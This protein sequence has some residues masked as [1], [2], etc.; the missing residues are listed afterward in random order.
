MRSRPLSS[1]TDSRDRGQVLVIFAL[2]LLT[3]ILFAA[4]AFD[5]GQMLLERRDQQDA[6]DAA[7]LAG[8]Y[9]LPDDP[10]T[11]RA[12][13]A[14]IAAANGFTDGTGSMEVDISTSP[15]GYVANSAIEVVIRNT[16]P[17]VFAGIMDIAGWTVGSRAVAVNEDHVSGPFA[18]LALDQ[19][20]CD[21]LLVTGNGTALANGNIQVNSDCATN[22]LHRG[23]GGSITVTATGAACN[24]VGG[25]QNPGDPD[26]TKL[27][28]TQNSPVPPIP[29]PLSGL[30]APPK[31]TTSTTPPLQV[32]GAAKAIPPQC[33]GGSAAATEA[34]PA[35]CQFPS[36]Y[37]GTTW[38]LYPGLYPGGIKLQG[39]TFYFEPGIY[40]I[41]G[42]GVDITGSGVVAK[43]VASGGTT[44]GGGVLFYNTQLDAFDVAC[45]TGSGTPAQCY[46]P[47]DLAG[48]TVDLQ[49]WPLDTGQLW[50]G[51]VIFLDR[52]FNYSRADPTLYDLTLNGS[53]TTTLV[54][55]TIYAP[56]GDVLANG[57]GGSLT[58]DQVIAFRFK[59]N[60]A[61]GATISVMYDTNFLFSFSAAGLAE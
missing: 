49:V 14:D 33:P 57:N 48:A 52:D 30:P 40:Y 22:A 19:H 59:I 31:P 53:A 25:I 29:D 13:A 16:R 18:M 10:V 26:G 32:G 3:L 15:T 11:A 2:S 9:Y 5:T 56:S 34:V 38:R 41:A 28:C 35:L 23:G 7:A 37:A 20:G 1:T 61:T 17:S 36:S 43:S 4:L 24:V 21:A 60:G 46:G 6:A 47:I 51:L 12:R 45:A 44:L 54:R 39:G 58:V 55:G 42:G 50:D 8:A 27:N